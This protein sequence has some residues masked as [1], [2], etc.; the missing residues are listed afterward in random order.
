MLK[1]LDGDGTY[2]SSVSESVD[3]IIQ[4]V[5][6]R[7]IWAPEWET[8]WATVYSAGQQIRNW[9]IAAFR[10]WIFTHCSR[11]HLDC[12]LFCVDKMTTQKKWMLVIS[13][14]IDSVFHAYPDKKLLLSIWSLRLLNE[15]EKDKEEKKMRTFDIGRGESLRHKRLF[16][17]YMYIVWF[18]M[19]I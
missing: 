17:H 9:S 18:S 5:I 11:R 3:C 14:H 16:V 6:Y 12:S 10:D 15:K 7:I 13:S 2:V 19:Q 4:R 8:N 1:D